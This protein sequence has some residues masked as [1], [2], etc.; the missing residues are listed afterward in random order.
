M[1]AEFV[2]FLQSINSRLAAKAPA[3]EF[4]PLPEG[5]SPSAANPAPARHAEV[6]VELKRDGDRISQIRIYCRCGEMIEL[7]CD[8]S[9]T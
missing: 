7:D 6:K 4:S 2:P 3:A 5:Q 1:S 8:Y 9:A